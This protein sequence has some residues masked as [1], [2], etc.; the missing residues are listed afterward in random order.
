MRPTAEHPALYAVRVA[1]HKL[2]ELVEDTSGD[3]API[4]PSWS[5]DGKWLVYGRLPCD[6]CA[7]EI[8]KIARGR[9]G[10][11]LGRLVASGLAPNVS[12]TGQILF[13]GVNGGLYT[14]AL[15]GSR[16][17]QILGPAQA[18]PG[19]DGPRMSPDG[20]QIALIRHDAHGR[21]WIETVGVDGRGRRRVTPVGAFA[22]P[23]WSPDGSQL[24]FARQGPDG[25]W[26]ICITDSRGKKL[27]V[28]S[29]PGH[30][31]SYPT[32]APDGQRLAF[33]RQTGL[34]HAVYSINVDGTHARRLTPTSMDAIEPAWSP[35]GG[36]IAFAVTG[37]DD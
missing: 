33:V 16:R 8:R 3:G 11:G 26:Q 30:S 5:K 1:D 36:E 19:V 2:T 24:A 25:L 17:H 35:L 18:P 21:N 32:W 28:V 34:T 7:P 12:V 23:S 10:T 27:R 9:S 13:I 31:D 6:G 14:V 15:D 4:A 20:R 22:N 29:P 37:S